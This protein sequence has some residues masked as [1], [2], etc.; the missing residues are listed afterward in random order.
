M[1]QV[2]ETGKRIG[3]PVGVAESGTNSFRV[4]IQRG[5][6]FGAKGGELRAGQKT[7]IDWLLVSQ[8]F[9]HAKTGEGT[10]VAVDRG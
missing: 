3:Y 4:D 7:L 6:A 5:V 2:C 8:V 9:L 1:K 10:D